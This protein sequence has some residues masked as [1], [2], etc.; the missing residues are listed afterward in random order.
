VQLPVIVDPV[1]PEKIT[2]DW[3]AFEAAGGRQILEQIGDQY[4]RDAVRDVVSQ[5]PA[6]RSAA[7]ATGEEW[8]SAVKGG[9]MS[10]GDFG[11]YIREYVE[12]GHLTRAEADSLLQRAASPA[13]RPTHEAYPPIEGVD[14]EMWIAATVGI[15][16]DKVPASQVSAYYDTC[17]FPVGR[18]EA[19]SAEWYQRL[20]SDDFLRGWYMKD[21]A[22]R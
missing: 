22:V 11:G 17:G 21:T 5:D 2:I 7:I 8:L 10:L 3:K 6:Q 12:G 13:D 19:I 1:V 20:Q 18:G 4:K 16:R 15:V 9:Y 14:Y